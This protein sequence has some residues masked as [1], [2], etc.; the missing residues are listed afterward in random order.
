MRCK[1][2]N[3]PLWTLKARTCP[4][5]GRPFAPSE[6]DFVPNAVRF[7]CPHC[8]QAYYG[9]DDR[10]HLTPR[11]FECVSC[12]T[13]IRMDDMIL[14]PA[15]GVAEAQTIPSAN[16]WLNR[17]E[18]GSFRAFFSTVG[19]ALTAPGTLMQRTPV[20]G[21]HA[22]AWALAVLV[23]F[24]IVAVAILPVTLLMGGIAAVGGGG[25]GGVAFLAGW[26]FGY[27]VAVFA[28]AMIV[29]VLWG[30]T[31]H[32]LLRM[33]GGSLHGIARTY[34]ALCYS[35]AANVL[36]AIPCFG[37]YFGWIWWAVSAV[38]MVKEAQQVGGGRA[39]LAVLA[40]PVLLVVTCFGGY[41]VFVAW[42][43]SSAGPTGGMTWAAAAA[44]GSMEYTEAQTV[45][46]ALLTYTGD[47]AGTP[48]PHALHLLVTDDLN[49]WDFVTIQASTAMTDVPV[50]DTDL[51]SL[52]I[53]HKPAVIKAADAA[54]AALPA[55]VIAHRVGN[56]VFTYHG[57]DFNSAAPL[58]IVILAHDPDVPTNATQ[59]IYYVGLTDGSVLPI[60][61]ATFPAQLAA[62][63]TL[64]AQQP[65]A[66]HPDPRTVTHTPPA[67]SQ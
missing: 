52:S 39:S 60:P 42:A 20:E 35:S 14:R 9:T 36:S 41:A 51:Q 34:Q 3:Y 30:A 6:F 66:P 32:V 19:M 7:C 31:A 64:R 12:K 26:T 13:F 45:T 57:V 5:C 54:A 44:T 58:W 43:M 27:I 25:P 17:R 21:G 29:I 37:F 15:E 24:V 59:A 4:E 50:G 55:D 11:Q 46:T 16:P 40:F 53:A 63:N 61:A 2:C 49:A 48:P 23:Q 18:R 38:L 28:V 33:T 47:H 22:A 8:D 56:F 1:S 65:L 10:G 62:Q 67:T